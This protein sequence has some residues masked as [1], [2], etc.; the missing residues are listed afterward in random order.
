MKKRIVSLLL[1]LCLL[2]GLLPAVTPQA[3][4]VISTVIGTSLKMCTSLVKG[5]IYA[6]RNGSEY[7]NA[8]Q[9]V[10]AVSNMRAAICSAST[11]AAAPAARRRRPSSR[12]ST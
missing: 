7:D 6:C 11:S 1:A 9:G 2:A 8:G 5:G 12:R 10:L 3:D 4:A